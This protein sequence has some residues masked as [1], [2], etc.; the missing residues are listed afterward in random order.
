MLLK[1]QLK[2]VKKL[3]MS[4]MLT[5]YSITI[6]DLDINN[7]K[8]TWKIFENFKGKQKSKTH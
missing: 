1:E 2:Q 3:I 6:K 4:L 8:D 5:N 7:F